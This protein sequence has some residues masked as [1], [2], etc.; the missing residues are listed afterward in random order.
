MKL[1]LSVR[2]AE[3][4]SDKTRATMSLE[5]LADLAVEHGYAAL[6]MRASQVGVRTPAEEVRAAAQQIRLRGL[7]V[8]MVTGDFPIPRTATNPLPPCATSR[9]TLT[10][11][12]CWA[13]ICCASR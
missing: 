5:G 7:A 2:V 8:S 3:S 9:P 13:L 4:F 10:W 6:C 12:R 1:S 11:R